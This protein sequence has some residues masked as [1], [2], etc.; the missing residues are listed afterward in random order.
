MVNVLKLGYRKDNKN[1]RKSIKKSINF[2]KRTAII[3]AVMVL[4]IASFGMPLVR[5]DSFQDKINQLQDDN[6]QKQSEKKVLRAQAD[7]LEATI[8]A[9]QTQIND[10]QTQIDINTAK[11]VDLQNQIEVAQVQLDQQKR[12]L[13]INI[14][15]MYLEGDITT[16]EMLA[17]SK[18]LGDYFDKAQYRSAVKDKIKDTL[19]TVTALKAQLK[20]QQ[21]KLKELIDQQIVLQGQLNNQK[22]EQN[23]LLNLNQGQR[24]ALDNQIKSNATALAQLRAA[25]AAALAA[26]MGANGQ[27][28]TG[29]PVQ[30]KN[31]SGSMNCGGGYS[32][33]WTYYDQYLT[34]T[35]NTW[36]LEWARECV[37][38]VADYL[39]REGKHVPNLSGKGNAN[40]WPQNAKNNPSG[41]YG[42]IT[43]NPQ[44]GDVVYMP[45]AW[46][47][48]VGI[49]EYVNS[50]GTVHISQ[51]NLPIGGYYSEMD[52]YITPG[53]EFIHF[54]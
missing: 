32:Y 19:D 44:H 35:L 25:Q 51:M 48:H 39:T 22:S 41:L 26:V 36:G 53:V 27:S 4:A 1:M 14:K 49:V 45:F 47:G 43:N 21:T 16:I 31:L 37:H 50:D 6:N 17:T 3:A 23:G 40:Q 24:A 12:I 10:S 33:C 8:N 29:A 54:D 9:L 28:K 42:R 2:S 18:D 11:S 5:A 38:Y 15:A 20:D 13:G 34:S 52:L 7:T 30:Y 46:P